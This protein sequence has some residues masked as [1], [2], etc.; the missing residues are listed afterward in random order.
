MRRD[1]KKL[2]KITLSIEGLKYHPDLVTIEFGDTILWTNNDERDYSV[3]ADDGS[4]DSG[5]LRKGMTFSKTFDKPGRFTYGSDPSART[6]GTV[7]VKEKKEEVIK[8]TSS[9]ERSGSTPT[10]TE[11]RNDKHCSADHARGLW[12]R[13]ERCDL[14][15]RQQDRAGITVVD[16]V[17]HVVVRRSVGRPAHLLGHSAA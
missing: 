1:G 11:L 3:K 2:Q 8:G 16:A 6:K 12:D 13:H 9:T 14:L 4:F 17:D 7:V 15:R 10:A 5:L